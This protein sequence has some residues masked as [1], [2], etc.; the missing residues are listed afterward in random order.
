MNSLHKPPISYQFEIED[1]LLTEIDFSSLPSL[2]DTSL[3][4]SISHEDP[5]EDISSL[6][7][8]SPSF[9]SLED[10]FA[11]D[12]FSSLNIEDDQGNSSF[13]ATN[14]TTPEE[15]IQAY[16]VS[17]FDCDSAIDLE[18]TK[19]SHP[20]H[21]KRGHSSALI[22][23]EKQL[24]AMYPYLSDLWSLSATEMDKQ[25]RP[26]HSSV[27]S[28]PITSVSGQRRLPYNGYSNHKYISSDCIQDGD[29]L[30]GRGKK[31]NNHPGNKYYRELI[32]RV[33]SQYK[34]C[35]RI[36][37]TALSTSIVD[38]IHE[39]GGRFLTPVSS[40]SNLWVEMTGLALRKKTSQAMRDSTAYRK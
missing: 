31:S 38:A 39:K 25:S 8:E 28:V 5:N 15:D 23:K 16:F 21:V 33:S 36:Q 2:D 6:L 29:V 3:A 11:N 40:K 22:G 18:H 4:N 32:L 26:L 34:D 17:S 12:C 14:D 20:S 13:L 30:F 9:H 35:S 19:C 10:A 1:P 27:K 24:D 7:S 37:K